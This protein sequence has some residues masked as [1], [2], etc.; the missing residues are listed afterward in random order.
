MFR[1]QGVPET[2][3]IDPAG[4]LVYVKKGPFLSTA[5]IQSVID[6]HLQ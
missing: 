1:I 6:P 4:K 2:Y 5:E 3:I